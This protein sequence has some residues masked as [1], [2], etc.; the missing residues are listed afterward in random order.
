MECCINLLGCCNIW[1]IFLIVNCDRWCFDICLSATSQNISW[2]SCHVLTT[3]SFHCV[4]SMEKNSLKL[5][6]LEF[7]CNLFGEILRQSYF[8]VTSWYFLSSNLLASESHWV[9]SNTRGRIR[10]N[11]KRVNWTCYLGSVA[12]WICYVT[13]IRLST[14]VRRPTVIKRCFSSFFKWAYWRSQAVWVCYIAKRLLMIS[15]ETNI[16]TLGENNVWSILLLHFCIILVR[17]I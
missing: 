9:T 5:F 13:L 2:S 16:T 7:E 4:T 10:Y 17:T 8:V 14:M 11:C 1:S 15:I 12:C 3:L 6:L